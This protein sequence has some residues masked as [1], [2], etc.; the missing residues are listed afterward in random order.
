MRFLFLFI[1]YVVSKEGLIKVP[2][3][4]IQTVFIVTNN[5][6]P[7]NSFHLIGTFIEKCLCVKIIE[8]FRI[9]D[10]NGVVHICSQLSGNY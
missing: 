7:N 2:V 4:V 10:T 5:C 9:N 8:N 3:H 6:A 1:R